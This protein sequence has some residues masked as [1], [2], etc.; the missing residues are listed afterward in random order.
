ML[1]FEDVGKWNFDKN[2]K[3]FED[4]KI[5]DLQLFNIFLL[6]MQV[7]CKRDNTSHT[8]LLFKCFCGYFLGNFARLFF[9]SLIY[10]F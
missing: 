9:F 1:K 8:N 6:Q 2:K 3:K 4:K 10:L 5:L 7:G